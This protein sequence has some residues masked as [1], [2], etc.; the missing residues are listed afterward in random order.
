[1]PSRR[2]TEHQMGAFVMVW[3][4]QRRFGNE[5][6]SKRWYLE[7]GLFNITNEKKQR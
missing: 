3:E 6:G 5:T 4:G 7:D 2:S 1:L